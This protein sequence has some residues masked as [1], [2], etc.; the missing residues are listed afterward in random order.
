MRDN[1]RL[2]PAV[3]RTREPS[4]PPPLQEPA[5]PASLE[6]SKVSRACELPEPFGR[7]AL[8]ERLSAG[9]TGEVWKAVALGEADRGQ[10]LEVKR[11]RQ[12][13]TSSGAMGEAFLSQ[14]REYLDSRSLLSVLGCLAAS[15]RPLPVE[16]AVFVAAKVAQGL[17]HLH[18]ARLPDGALLAPAHLDVTPSGIVLLRSGQVKLLDPGFPPRGLL[19]MA[20]LKETGIYPANLPYLAPECTQGQLDHRCDIFSLGVVLWESLIGRSLFRG[21]TR[22]ETVRN[23][24]ERVIPPPSHFRI[25]VPRTL[26]QVVMQALERDPE[27]RYPDAASMALELDVLLEEP[28]RCASS[29]ARMLE[30]IADAD[31]AMGEADL[32]GPV[33]M[34]M[35]Q[36]T[37]AWGVPGPVPTGP[38][39]TS[40]PAP[41][42]PPPW[43]R[44]TLTVPR[45]TA[46]A[47]AAGSAFAIGMSG[48]LATNGA[49]RALAVRPLDTLVA[50]P[51]AYEQKM[52]LPPPPA[53]LA[54]P[55]PPEPAGAT[56]GPPNP[57]T[58]ARV[59]E[60][61]PNRMPKAPSK[62]GVTL[63]IDPF[64]ETQAHARR[65]GGP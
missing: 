11:L 59:R 45:W 42:P 55:P 43:H 41:V 50:P 53:D 65:P 48:F 16:L 24:R 60:A 30:G 32:A 63:T 36:G 39:R 34:P 33:L 31:P 38:A 1:S 58:P 5:A 25:D 10:I 64:A 44:R 4:I 23:L 52:A 51:Q 9:A 35:L 22:A 57:G 56:V 17:V 47:L 49:V 46:L 7:Y 54:L 3:V 37:S 12:E 15:K 20:E 26:D 40:R 8:L 62:V 2:E 18:P 19:A 27:R 21:H 61:R 29:M 14:A 13:L 28:S 6:A